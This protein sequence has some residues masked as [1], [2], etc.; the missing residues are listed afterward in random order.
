MERSITKKI[1]RNEE[2]EGILLKCQRC[3]H[4][5]EYKGINP[6]I[7]SCPFCHT[8]VRVRKSSLTQQVE[9]TK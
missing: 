6:Y 7:C 8:S 9:V 4:N 1:N 5:W 3:D 2:E